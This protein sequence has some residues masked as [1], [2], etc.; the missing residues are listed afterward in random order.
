MFVTVHGAACGGSRD[1]VDLEAGPVADDGRFAYDL[2]GCLVRERDH[3]PVAADVSANDFPGRRFRMAVGFVLGKLAHRSDAVWQSLALLRVIELA[4][5]GKHQPVISRVLD[6][7]GR[8]DD[9][10]ARVVASEN[11]LDHSVFGADVLEAP[12]NAGGDVDDVAFVQHDLAGR[13]PAAP[14]EPPAAGEDEEDFGGA[15]HVKRVPA[16]WRLARRADVESM[17]EI[18]VDVLVRAFRDAAADDREILLLVGARGMG[19]DEG[20]LARLEFAV[21]D[22]SVF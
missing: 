22:D 5:L 20:G 16:L 7:L 1:Q 18:D 6:H 2:A 15:V 11:R 14:E 8:P 17:G 4:G 13:A 12:E 3:V 21:A 19:V 9:A 10:A